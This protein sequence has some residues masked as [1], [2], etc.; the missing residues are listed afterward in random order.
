M[1]SLAILCCLF[2]IFMPAVNLARCEPLLYPCDE[3]H[4]AKDASRMIKTASGVLAPVYAP[5]AEQIVAEFELAEN[6]GIGI[7]IGSGPGML[8][9]EL[10]KRTRLH[11][12]NADINP[13]F[14]AH[15]FESIEEAGLNGRVSAIF[16][17]AQ[18][19]PFRDDYAEVIVSR[20]SFQFWDDKRLAFSE[21]Y[22]VLKPGGV[23]F[24]GRGL[25]DDLPV[26]TACEIR[27]A[28]R[29]RGEKSV[30]DY[31]VPETEAEIRAL[32]KALRIEDYR[33]H[34]PKP[35]GSDGINYG[36]WVE[37]RK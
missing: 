36:I 25:P 13:H 3:K 14:F 26:E 15:F 24:I 10:C 20:G 31:S 37:I 16:V 8:V 32:M 29:K 21:I 33:I 12:I 22:R 19:L 9:V 17:D 35:P 2:I 4:S 1:K 7:D 18:A 30:L 34:I 28:Q 27:A 23:A 6:E 5:L 11:W